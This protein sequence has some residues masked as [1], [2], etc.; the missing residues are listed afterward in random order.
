MTESDFEQ[1][2]EREYSSYLARTRYD[3]NHSHS[4]K[5]CCSRLSSNDSHHDGTKS[6]KNVDCQKLSHTMDYSVGIERQQGS[7]ELHFKRG[8]R[9]LDL[10]GVRDPKGI[11]VKHHQSTMSVP[12]DKI[13]RSFPASRLMDTNTHMD[14]QILTILFTGILVIPHIYH[15]SHKIHPTSMVL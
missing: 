14:I 3:M 10:D 11:E 13:P 5:C 15:P 12:A 1:A 2:R 6:G 4:S 8:N 7:E 9:I